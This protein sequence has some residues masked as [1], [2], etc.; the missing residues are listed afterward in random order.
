MDFPDPLF[1]RKRSK[2]PQLLFR[3]SPQEKLFPDPLRWGR[4]EGKKSAVAALRPLP[5]PPP[6]PPPPSPSSL[7]AFAKVNPCAECVREPTKRRLSPIEKKIGDG[8][9]SKNLALAK[10]APKVWFKQLLCVQLPRV[11]TSRNAPLKFLPSPSQYRRS[12]A[13]PAAAVGKETDSLPPTT[14]ST[15][16]GWGGGGG[17]VGRRRGGGGRKGGGGGGGRRGGRGRGGGGGGGGGGGRKFGEAFWV[18]WVGG[19]STLLTFLLRERRREEGEE[20]GYSLQEYEVGGDQTHWK[21]G[22]GGGILPPRFHPWFKSELLHL[23]LFFWCGKIWIFVSQKNILRDFYPLAS[24]SSLPSLQEK[25][26]R[27]EGHTHT[28]SG[29]NKEEKG[30]RGEEEDESKD[31]Q[32]LNEVASLLLPLSLL[33]P[34]VCVEKKRKREER[35]LVSLL[36]SLCAHGRRERERDRE[37]ERERERKD[38]LHSSPEDVFLI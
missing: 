3:I 12:A 38:F 4:K 9:V 26:E 37:R 31:K 28:Q 18:G 13:Y 5:P 25:K 8:W 36:S 7:L 27:V 22:R 21:R 2:N 30:G 33:P 20:D 32:G 29:R 19:D 15:L 6:P 23:Q 35:K 14:T 10:F 11:L 1:L 16:L 17:G 24:S 34:C